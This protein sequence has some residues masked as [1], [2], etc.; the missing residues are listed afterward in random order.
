MQNEINKPIFVVGFPGSGTSVLTWCLGEHPNIIALEESDGM[1]D[2]AID[3]EIGTAH[4]DKS[5]LSS[6]DGRKARFLAAF[7]K[8]INGLIA[9]HRADLNTA[10]INQYRL[11]VAMRQQH[12]AVEIETSKSQIQ[13][14]Q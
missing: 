9:G 12:Y 10:E 4:G 7:G 5:L 1:G 3:Y 13:N 6:M 8:S 11:Q 2:L 14:V